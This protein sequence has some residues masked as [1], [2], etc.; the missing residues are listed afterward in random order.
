M[1]KVQVGINGNLTVHST[2]LSGQQQRKHKSQPYWPF[3][4]GMHWWPVY[5]DGLVQERCNSIANALELRLS[6][7]NPS[8]FPHKVPAMRKVFPC[9]DVF[10]GKITHQDLGRTVHIQKTLLAQ[11]TKFDNFKNRLHRIQK[12][13]LS[14]P[15]A[16][17]NVLLALGHR[18]MGYVEPAGEVLFSLPGSL[19]RETI[20]WFAS[21][22]RGTLIRSFDAFCVYIVGNFLPCGITVICIKVSWI[23][24]FYF[25]AYGSGHEGGPV[26]L[27]DFAIIW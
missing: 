7:T 12:K 21:L 20:S 9:H 22:L 11:L 6:C 15:L 24:F 1:F 17:L 19:C 25:K 18:A 26:L 5:F 2:A 14:N 27:S 10:M 3:V 23:F 16:W 8:I 4:S 13:F